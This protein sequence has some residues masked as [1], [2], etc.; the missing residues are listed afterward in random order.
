MKLVEFS[1]GCVGT[2][3]DEEE[4]TVILRMSE[5]YTLTKPERHDHTGSVRYWLENGYNSKGWR[6]VP[7][8]TRDKIIDDIWSLLRDGERFRELQATLQG[9]LLPSPRRG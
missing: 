2:E 4:K 8:E 6:D 7:E 1:C 5:G 3:P 9:M